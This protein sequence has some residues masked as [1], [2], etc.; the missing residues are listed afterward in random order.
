[1]SNVLFTE[2]ANELHKPVRTQFKTR[3]V[4]VP[5]MDYEYQM[6]LSDVSNIKKLNDNYTFLFTCIDVFSKYAWVIPIRN[7]TGEEILRAIK[8]VFKERKPS[9][10]QTDKGKEFL[11]KTVKDYLKK[12]NVELFQTHNEAKASVVERFNRSIK[13]ITWKYFTAHNT[14]RYVDV[15]PDIVKFYNT[16]K[17]RSI[18]MAPIEVN[19]NNEITVSQRL[20]GD[21]QE[22]PE[23]Q[24]TKFKE[25]DYVRISNKKQTFHKGYLGNWG[26]E[27]F[28]VTKVR[29]TDP[30]VY[31]L[32]DSNDEPIEGS[33]YKEE[34][35]KT[36]KPEIYRI[37]KVLK[38]RKYKGKDQL[39][40]RW[41]NYPDSFNSWIDSSEAIKLNQDK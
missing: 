7:K 24:K 13:E 40:V 21:V 3:K 29:Y 26:E 19:K 38:K 17:H 16:R 34:L 36:K 18:G 41:S 20:Y 25:G 30:P 8:I 28:V 39:F 9:K 31:L 2:L 6:D 23:N 37:E 12:E 33:F 14:N 4:I 11:N 32:N 22:G 10:I 35:Q 1:M 27:I 5:G 15:L